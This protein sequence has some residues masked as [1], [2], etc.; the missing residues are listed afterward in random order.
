VTALAATDLLTRD[1]NLG[2]VVLDLRD[3]TEREL[4]R[5][6]AS[7]WYRLQRAVEPADLALVVITPRATVPSAQLRFVLNSSTPPPPRAR[8]PRA[9]D[10]ARART[11]S[12]S[13]SM[14]APDHELSRKPRSHEPNLRFPGF[15]LL[16]RVFAVLYLA[17][18]ALHAVL[19]T[20]RE[21]CNRPAALFA[22]TGKKSSSLPPRRPARAAGV[23]LGMTAP[24]AVARCPALIIRAPNAA[25]E[26][27]AR[28]RSSPS[29]SRSRPRSRTTAPGICTIDLRGSARRE[30]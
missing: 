13:D 10:R 18:F 5:T 23:E 4:R 2:L 6:P 28:A 11:S 26:A 22:G 29:P 15:L 7:F 17:D 12:A 9:L 25:A 8:A 3:L 30:I 16:L 19:R 14:P 21:N 1:A 20:E 24:Q 27:E